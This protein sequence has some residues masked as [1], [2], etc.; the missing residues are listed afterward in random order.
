M[1]GLN[2]SNESHEAWKRGNNKSFAARRREEKAAA[3]KSGLPL[4]IRCKEIGGGLR[5][6]F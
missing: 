1:Q 4:H 6:R 5:D 3:L 2:I